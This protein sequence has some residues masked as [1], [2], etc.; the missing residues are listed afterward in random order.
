[1]RFPRVAV[2]LACLGKLIRLAPV[3]VLGAGAL[4]SLGSALASGQPGGSASAPPG[5]GGR[6]RPK[7]RMEAD[8]FI[9]KVENGEHVSYMLGHVFIDRDSLTARSD[10]AIYFRERE[11]YEFMGN[12]VVTGTVRCSN[13]RAAPTTVWP[14]REISTAPCG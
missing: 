11:F 10:T 9:D 1:M 8:R 4:L 13:A 6:S 3:A 7:S 14:G 5:E 12:V 2:W